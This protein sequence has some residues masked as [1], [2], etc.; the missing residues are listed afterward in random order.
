[1]EL[2][3]ATMQVFV[4]HPL[5]AFIFSML[6]MMPCFLPHF[7]SRQ[8]LVLCCSTLVW[9][10]YGFWE[11]YMSQVSAGSRGDLAMLGPFVLFFAVI[12]V[13]TI[14]RGFLRPSTECE[15]PYHVE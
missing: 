5:V 7:S 6:F 8:K 12:A 11:T 15:V 14:A 10:L 2:L 9:L 13:I 1:M 4:D 3:L